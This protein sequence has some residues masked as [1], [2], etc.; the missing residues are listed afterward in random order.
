MGVCVCVRIIVTTASRRWLPGVYTW[1]C[2]CEFVWEHY[3]VFFL[4]LCSTASTG[5]LAGVCVG[6]CVCG[7]VWEHCCVCECVGAHLC[8]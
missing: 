8:E 1:V 3:C 6:E 4:L 2:M 7:F 5:W